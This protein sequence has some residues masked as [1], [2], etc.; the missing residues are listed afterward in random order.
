[1]KPW[2]S[3]TRIAPRI[4]EIAEPLH[5]ENVRS[6]LLVGDASAVLFDTGMG[7]GDIGEAVRS[8]TDLP[9]TAVCSHADFDHVGGAASFADVALPDHPRARAAAAGYPRPALG[10][11][12]A[13]A[14]FVEIPEGFDYGA[15]G[16]PPFRAARYL[17]EGDVVEAAPFRL[18]VVAAPGHTPDSICLFDDATGL[19]LAGDALYEGRIFV[20]DFGAF[21][22][23]VR[24]LLALAP[25]RILPAHN[26][27]DFTPGRL[28]ELAAALAGRTSLALGET[29]PV[30]GRLAVLGTKTWEPLPAPMTT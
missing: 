11:T 4:W 10:E 25:R 12:Y 8:V 2:F 15:F 20:S 24:K 30:S 26:G 16:L 1:M 28:A 3:I 6:Y 13:P 18:R 5:K 22:A 27:S 23:T 29:V 9:V 7:V 17:R 19:L 21:A 14:G